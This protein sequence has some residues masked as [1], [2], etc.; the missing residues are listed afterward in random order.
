MIAPSAEDY[1]AEW[2]VTPARG[3]RKASKNLWIY[4]KLTNKKRY[5]VTSAAGAKIQP[6]FDIPAP[7]DPNLIHFRVQGEELDS[8][9]V[10]I[11]LNCGTARELSVL[12]G[13]LDVATLSAAISDAAERTM[14]TSITATVFDELAQPVK[15]TKEAYLTLVN[16]W[17][18]VSDE[19]R[20]QLL[21]HTL[22]GS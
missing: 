11:W 21:L 1:W 3:A 8:N 12:L 16:R 17:D 10:L 19:H 4:D 7:N 9:L 20:A 5:S 13:S 14:D 18:G 15:L 22:R 6:Y 2:H